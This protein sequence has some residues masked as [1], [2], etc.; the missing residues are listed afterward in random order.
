MA[1]C[2]SGSGSRPKRL[3]ALQAANLFQTLDSEDEIES[4]TSTSSSS[5]DNDENEMRGRFMDSGSSEDEE[6]GVSGGGV[7]PQPGPSRRKRPRLD[8]RGDRPRPRATQDRP[9]PPYLWTELSRSTNNSRATTNS[10][11]LLPKD[12]KQ[13]GLNDALIS[14]TSTV[15]DCYR[16]LIADDVID[17]MIQSINEYA[18]LQIMKNTPARRRSWFAGWQP[19]TKYELLK[20]FAVMNAMGLDPRPHVRDFTSTERSMKTDFYLEMFDRERLEALY[21]TM[22]HV[23]EPEAAGKSKIEPFVEMLIEKFNNAFTPYQNV[24]IDEMIIGWKGRWKYKQFNAAKPHKY[25]IKSFGLVDSSTGYVLNLLTYYGAETSYDPEAD[26]DVQGRTSVKIFQTLLKPIGVGYHIFADRWYTTRVLIDTMIADK[27]YYTGTVQAQRSGFPTEIRGKTSLAHKES[28]YWMS[29][30]N[31]ILC[32]AY[33]DKK[34]K[35]QVVMVTTKGHVDEPVEDGGEVK[36]SVIQAYNFSMNGCDRADQMVGYYGLHKRRSKKWWKKIFFW[37][38]EIAC[39][40][41]YI[42]YSLSRAGQTK[43][44]G[45]KKFKHRLIDQ[46][47]ESAAAI[48]PEHEQGSVKRP[49]RPRVNPIQRLEGAKHLISYTPN[50]RRCQVCSTPR[51]VKRTNFVCKGCDGMPHLHPKHCFEKWHTDPH[52]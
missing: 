49:G 26:T 12:G 28:K 30:E 41:A 21:H 33:R 22:L 14:E 44:I 17:A 27:Q 39:V 48:M 6:V 35:K 25:H 18:E 50:D 7:S 51:N 1:S 10:F 8:G 15:L 29:S 52:L 5:D 4:S 16:T 24:S 42:L 47:C 36:P 20:F 31:K 46:L 45:L 19:V 9:I 37:V 34:A 11:R 43:K 23:G 32:V 2:S 40:N 3:T 13:P 38:M